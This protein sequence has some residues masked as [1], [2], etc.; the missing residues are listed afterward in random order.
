MSKRAVLSGYATLDF[1][2]GCDAAP[3]GAGTYLAEIHTATAWPRAGG[4][5]LYAGG[6]LAAAGHAAAPLAQIGDDANGA[7]Y[8]AA[9]AAAGVSTAG[10][11]TVDGASPC[12]ILVHH[13]V[14][15]VTCYLDPG[16]REAHALTAAQAA[17]LADA[18]LV[19]VCAGP[20][21]VTEDLLSRLRPGQALAWIAKGDARC[22]PPALRTRLLARAQTVFCNAGERGF[23]EAARLASP[24]DQ[25]FI[26]TRGGDGV[27]VQQ[28]GV[29][30]LY[31]I[32]PIKVADATGA[33]DTFAGAF[34][35][36]RLDGADAAAATH[37]AIAR[38]AAF[39][40]GRTR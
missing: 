25:L 5:A 31:P 16:A 12:C 23:V 10:I 32:S 36:A 24:A 30:T 13:T 8:L 22:F 38:T 11:D 26:E 7:A 33:G 9:C 39:L 21:S 27:C 37:A 15:S 19:V 3:T 1:V 18:D 35:A 34:L 14:G 29:Q 20:A 2:V 28:H 17:A 6:R 4:A 40:G